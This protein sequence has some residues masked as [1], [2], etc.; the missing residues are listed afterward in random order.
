M[1]NSTGNYLLDCLPE[2]LRVGLLR[3]AERVELPRHTLLA[4]S[5]TLPA[6]GYFLCEGLAS[7]VVSMS[8]GGAAEVAMCG[9]D[10]LVGAFSLLGTQPSSAGTFMQVSGEGYRVPRKV[11][12]HLFQAEEDFR[13]LVLAWI[14]IT[15]HTSLQTS[16]CGLLHEAEARLARWLLMTCDRTD[17]ETMDLTQEFLAQMLGTQRTTVALIAGNLRKS[18]LIEYTRGRL[19]ILN[20]A[21]LQAAACECYGV[22]Q[23]SLLH[24]Y[25]ALKLVETPSIQGVS[26]TRQ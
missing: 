22:A 26:G 4:D 9:K 24:L 18:G 14:Q 15:L 21:G 16:A 3:S 11:L 13:K 7:L 20:R 19:R 12:E 25:P 1:E 2:D 5:E 17:S 10:G 6:Y 23:S 8:G